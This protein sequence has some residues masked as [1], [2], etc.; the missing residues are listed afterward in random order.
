M[1]RLKSAGEGDGAV[2]RRAR[3]VHEF[4]GRTRAAPAPPDILRCLKRFRRIAR[5]TR[6]RMQARQ[7]ARAGEISRRRKLKS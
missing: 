7:A 4:Q 1:S 3:I 6:P 2:V 5:C